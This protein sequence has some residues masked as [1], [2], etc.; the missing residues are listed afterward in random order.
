[1]YFFYVRLSLFPFDV[2]VIIIVLTMISSRHVLA[3]EQKWY[4][5]VCSYRYGI[6]AVSVG[7]YSTVIESVSYGLLTIQTAQIRAFEPPCA[8]CS[9]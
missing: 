6:V 7:H 8:T 2:Y 4:F 9:H 5:V 1:M 3:S